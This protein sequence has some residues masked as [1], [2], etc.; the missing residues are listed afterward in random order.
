MAGEDTGCILVGGKW[1]IAATKRW[2]CGQLPTGL[3]NTQLLPGGAEV[4]LDIADSA[5]KLNVLAMVVAMGL[6]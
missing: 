5:F 3:S 1:F 6:E 4:T 2:L